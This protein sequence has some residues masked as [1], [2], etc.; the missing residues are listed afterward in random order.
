MCSCSIKSIL[1][2]F[3]EATAMREEGILA[4]N[5]VADYLSKQ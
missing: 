5:F 1:Q 3:I 4:K 2:E